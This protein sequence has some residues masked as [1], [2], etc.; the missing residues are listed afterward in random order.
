MK[1]LINENS[2]FKVVG[3]AHENPKLLKES[4]Y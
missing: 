2:T 1:D 3:N 4:M